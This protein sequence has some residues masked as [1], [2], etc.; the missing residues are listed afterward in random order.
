MNLATPGQLHV[1][2]SEDTFPHGARLECHECGRVVIA[3]SQNCAAYLKHGWEM[4][5]GET[6]L[7]THI[8]DS[9]AKK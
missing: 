4:C 7:L 5:C 6:M 9:E 8:L 3:T 2:I 1:R